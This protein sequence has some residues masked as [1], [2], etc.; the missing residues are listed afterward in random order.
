VYQLERILNADGFDALS[1][2]DGRTMPPCVLVWV[3]VCVRIVY[4]CVYM[5]RCVF[6]CVCVLR[7]AHC[8]LCIV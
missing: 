7:I 3:D 1:A 5:C 2:T 4:V 6:A 8:V